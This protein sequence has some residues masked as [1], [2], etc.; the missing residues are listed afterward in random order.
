MEPEPGLADEARA[1]HDRPFRKTHSLEELGE[2]C[3]AIEPGLR[4]IVDRAV[5]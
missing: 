1:W 2:A 4:P 5:P 3:L